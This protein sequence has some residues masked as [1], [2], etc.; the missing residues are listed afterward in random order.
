MKRLHLEFDLDGDIDGLGYLI[1][2]RGL[3]KELNKLG[4]EVS[5]LVIGYTDEY[6]ESLK[7]KKKCGIENGSKLWVNGE[8]CYWY[9]GKLIPV[10]NTGSITISNEEYEPAWV[11][12][13]IDYKYPDG[14]EGEY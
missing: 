10:A 3:E 6:K 13:K 4:I 5:D 1:N 14:Y 7:P 9:D 11:N 8:Q 2:E 12:P